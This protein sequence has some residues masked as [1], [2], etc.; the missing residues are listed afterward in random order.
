MKRLTTIGCGAVLALGVLAGCG[1]DD[2]GGSGSDDSTSA[3]GGDYCSEVEKAKDAMASS[4]NA[5]ATLDDMKSQSESMA[6]VAEV[7][8][9]DVSKSWSNLA[10]FSEKLVS[11]IE[12]SGVAPDKPL[13]EEM[14]TMQK[15]DPE[16][17][18]KLQSSMPQQ[19][20]SLPDDGKKI[21]QQVKEECDIDLASSSSP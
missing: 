8:P 10:D 12:D 3:S 1:S 18:M 9:E 20:K 15:E 5:S 2:G 16:A 11:T 21:E 13:S 4:A 7:A 19:P 14:A 17:A 6:A